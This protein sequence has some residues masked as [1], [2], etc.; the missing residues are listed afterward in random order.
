MIDKWMN[1]AL[2]LSVFLLSWTSLIV[3]LPDLLDPRIHAL[4]NYGLLIIV[5]PP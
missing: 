2:E 4:N 5:I 3:Y 1:V